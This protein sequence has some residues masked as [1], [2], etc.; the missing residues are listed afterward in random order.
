M[1][2]ARRLVAAAL[3][4]GYADTYP[5]PTTTPIVGSYPGPT[6][7]PQRATALVASTSVDPPSVACPTANTY[8]VTV[9]LLTPITAPGA[10]DDDLDALLDAS[11]AAFDA[12]GLTFA[13]AV[14]GVWADQYPS[15]VVTSEVHP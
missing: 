9:Y 11:L 12:A 15:Y 13:T 4:D 8:T 1:R 14:R 7:P 2:D 6:D 5:D 10:G 3:E